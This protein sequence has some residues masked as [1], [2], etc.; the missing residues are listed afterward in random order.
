M[1]FFLTVPFSLLIFSAITENL[2]IDTRGYYK[3]E[4]IVMQNEN[5]YI[6]DFKKKKDFSDY[7]FISSWEKN[8][9]SS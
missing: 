7:Q 8:Y 3:N 5:N 4:E 2:I 6:Y 9:Q 1:K